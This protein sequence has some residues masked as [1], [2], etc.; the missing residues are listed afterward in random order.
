M[1]FHKAQYIFAHNVAKAIAPIMKSTGFRFSKKSRDSKLIN[2]LVNRVEANMMADG[3][4]VQPM[5][6]A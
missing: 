1:S 5:N 6:V 4:D 2:F 3:F